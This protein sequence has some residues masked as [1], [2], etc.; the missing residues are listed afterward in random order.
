[1]TGVA[2]GADRAAPVE[3]Q[4]LRDLADWASYRLQLSS[5]TCDDCVATR[6]DVLDTL[7]QLADQAAALTAL[8]EENARLKEPV[9]GVSAYEYGRAVDAFTRQKVRAE[10][11]EAEVTALRGQLAYLREPVAACVGYTLTGNPDDDDAQL[12]DRLAGLEAERAAM[13]PY[14]QHHSDCPKAYDA[15]WARIRHTEQHLDHDEMDKCPDSVC[16]AWQW[17]QVDCTCGLD[18][19]RRSRVPHP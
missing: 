7:R 4:H 10:T 1:M 6:Q 8:R 18:T 16:R 19:L 15:K 11:A 2:G 12:V 13:G 14:L 9:V 17:G 5:C 3:P